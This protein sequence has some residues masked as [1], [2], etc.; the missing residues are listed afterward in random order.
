[1]FGFLKKNKDSPIVK[2]EYRPVDLFNDQ[3]HL[4][5]KYIKNIAERSYSKDRLLKDIERRNLLCSLAIN[6][7][8][9]GSPGLDQGSM[10]TRNITRG[11][12]LSDDVIYKILNLSNE[13]YVRFVDSIYSEYCD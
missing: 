7:C 1:M 5:I 13:D 6:F 11:L 10:E 4:V 12:N 9:N 8:M 3:E 2:P